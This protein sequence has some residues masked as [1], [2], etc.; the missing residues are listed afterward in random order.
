M[1]ST[2]KT[3]LQLS[4]QYIVQNLSISCI[5]YKTVTNKKGKPIDFEFTTANPRFEELTGIKRKD[6]IGKKFSRVLASIE[7]H[8]LPLI[9]FLQK[10]ALSP[11][12]EIIEQYIE[13]V[14]I[15]L[16]VQVLPLE[17][18]TFLVLLIDISHR[19]QAEKSLQEREYILNERVKEL[20][21]LYGIASL[22]QKGELSIDE[23]C[24][25]VIKLI[26]P[27]MQY[28]SITCVRLV[29]GNQKYKTK[30]FRKTIWKLAG[31]IRL[32]KKTA[33]VLEVYYL[34]PCP[35]FAIGSFFIEKQKLIDVITER[36]GRIIERKRY[37]E[38]LTVREEKYRT[39]IENV[40]VGVYRNTADSQ[41]RFLEANPAMIRILDYKSSEELLQHSVADLYENPQDRKTFLDKIKKKGVVKNEELRLK[42]KDGTLIIASIT[43]S[44]HRN[45][46]G[47]IDWFDGVIED[48]T[49]R[50]RDEQ[51]LRSE[52]DK[53]QGMLSAMKQ[54]VDI[55]NKD[56]I[57]EFQNKLLKERFGDKRGEKCYITYMGLKEPCDICMMHEAIR[58]GQTTRVE[59]VGA[60]GR[61]YEVTSSPFTDIDGEVKVIE[62][63]R[64]I[65]ERKQSEEI[66]KESEE[67]YRSLVKNVNIGIFRTEP[68]GTGRFIE[69]NPALVHML[70]YTSEKELMHLSPSDLYMNPI[71]RADYLNK[72]K[73]R[74]FIAAEELKFKKKNGVIFMVSVTARIHRDEKDK[75][76]WIDGV[77]EDI[78][79]RKKTEDALKSLSSRNQ[80]LLSAVPDII[81]EVDNNKVYTWANQTGYD[82]FG[83]DV[84]GKEASFY[85]EGEQKTY[86]IVRSLFNGSENLIYLESWQRRKDGKKRL[87]AWWCRTLKDSQGKV[88]GVLST[89]MD[90]TNRKQ[91]EQALRDGELRYR[92]LIEMSPYAIATH[93]EGKVIFINP[94]GVHLL[95][96]KNPEEIIGKP[97]IE[98]VHPE[99]RKLVKERVMRMLKT[100]KEEPAT[101]EKF[102]CLDGS[103]VDVEVLAKPFIYH[104]KLAVMIVASDITER[105]RAEEEQRKKVEQTIFFQNNLLKLAKL[106][107]VSLDTSIKKITETD[108][109]TLNV[110]R[111]SFWLFSIDYSELVCEDL[112]LKS[113]DFHTKGLKL[114][115][116]NFPRY[117]QVLKK[118]RVIAANDACN[119]TCT[120]EFAESY[121]KPFGITSM[122]D[123]PIRLQGKVVGVICHEHIGIMRKWTIE[124]QNF[125]TSIADMVSLTLESVE[126]NR[127]EEIL[128]VNEEKYRSLVEN[129][130]IGVYRN[131]PDTKG[132]FLEV[133]PAMVKMFGYKSPEEMMQVSV[134]DL[135]QNP[136]DRKNLL[137]KFNR[138]GFVT[139]EEIR[140]K[141]KDGSPIIVRLFSRVHKNNEGKV[142]WIDGVIEDVTER[143]RAEEILSESEEKYRSLV[144]NVTVGIY[145][146]SVGPSGKILE[147][148]SAL[149]K[150]L[151]FKSAE[152]LKGTI[153]TDL[154]QNPEERKGFINKLMKDGFIKT[155]ELRLRKKDGTPIIA[156]DT[157]YAHKDKNGRIDWIDGVIEDI[158]E[159]KKA[160]QARYESEEKYRNVV[161]RANDG[162]VIITDRIIR[163]ANR[164][165][166]DILKIGLGKIIGKPFTNFIHPDELNQI[167]DNYKKRMA[168]RYVPSVYETAL[169]LKD[170]NKIPVELNAGT[171]MFQNKL[172]DLVF[173]RDL[174]ERKKAEQ[175]L[176][177]SEERYRTIF[178]T[179]NDAICIFDTAGNAISGNQRLFELT[180]I[181]EKELGSHISTYP[182][183]PQNSLEIIKENMAARFAGKKVGPYEVELHPIKGTPKTVEINATLLRYPD[184]EVWGDLAIIRDITERKQYENALRQAKETAENANKAK[185]SF[186]HNMS[187]ELRTPMTAILGFTDLL[188]DR[189]K[190]REQE[191]MLEIVKN[192]SSHLLKII[193]DLLD[194]SRIE[195]GKMMLEKTEC[196]IF[197]AVQEIHKSFGPLARNKGIDFILNIN[198]N[199]PEFIITDRTKIIQIISN[200]LDNAFKFTEQGKIELYIG[201]KTPAKPS[202]NIL[203][204]H[205]Q[206]TGIGVADEHKAQIFEKFVLGEHYISKKYGGAGLGLP[207]VKELV[208]LMHGNISF[209]SKLAKGT[210]FIVQIPVEI[211]NDKKRKEQA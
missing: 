169:K 60:D 56:Y 116:N 11:T 49:E 91:A 186:L 191:E 176:R 106:D 163:F 23:I 80:A 74:G 170:G 99:Y 115:I 112:Y 182:I 185:T 147:A 121:L 138:D 7:K 151:G 67:K 187:H 141:K 38:Q 20:T 16:R 25:S 24:N 63:I 42:K 84:I 131:T 76:N 17:K 158:T 92:T 123:V 124:E 181:A 44:A 175:A 39:L 206:D 41:G 40:N 53:F 31:K 140:L 192:S 9:K 152:K 2:E 102:V 177:D 10:I 37:E 57:I 101:E 205:V 149:A 199:L 156:S 32:H 133:N 18:W 190:N 59:L 72:L 75:I 184:G 150:L 201:L 94:A 153:V 148:N 189:E 179:A 143:K 128:K 73:K 13:S 85:F 70:G 55:V 87:L 12:N 82:F 200:L 120:S 188:L 14:N 21:C 77:V 69:V 166:A 26:P 165:V 207:I 111:V 47:R 93:S 1:K 160:E 35:N 8:K 33:G 209:K 130:T 198:K 109:K 204:F 161:E 96:A 19:K 164:H 145:R 79:E 129:V 114:Q 110:E 5:C 66:L 172:A 97:V 105:K 29:M 45:I 95:K 15:W 154:F 210:K 178:E 104:N 119:D 159:H 173:I 196:N 197:D 132:R 167:A 89:A 4:Y 162:I 195:A 98:I 174:T 137:K 168:G 107:I 208:E 78:T 6:I 134:S 43:A 126:R 144:E 86:E 193:N 50:K 71:D 34:K 136:Q 65:T 135:Y 180:G 194:L 61:N 88:T 100:G 51:K 171:I 90:I 127:V 36:L 28:P 202:E 62:L 139:G 22:I 30:N 122:M 211:V 103:Y 117:F 118:G 52:Y 48:I 157:A 64:D 3:K 155:D 27:A 46:K 83:N 125:A 142:D 183:F 68:I 58:T 54:G 203:E 108:A 146:T 113:K 81:M